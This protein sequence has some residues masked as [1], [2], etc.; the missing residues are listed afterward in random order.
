MSTYLLAFTVSEF[1]PTTSPHERV[2]IKVGVLLYIQDELNVIVLNV[3]L[4]LA[5]VI[6]TSTSFYHQHLEI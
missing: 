5:S 2:E 4:T 1:L 6:V 3:V